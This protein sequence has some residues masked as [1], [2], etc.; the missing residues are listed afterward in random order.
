MDNNILIDDI[1]T[2]A[3]VAGYLKL[4]EKTVLRMVHRGEIPCVKIAS[5]WRFSRNVIDDWLLSRMQVLPKNDLA[6]IIE[7]DS[8]VLPLSRLM[9]PGF[10]QP[11]IRPGSKEDVLRQLIQLLVSAKIVTDEEQ[12]LGK[13]LFRE[14]MA[15]TAIGNGAA[16]PHVRNPEELKHGSPLIISG[17]CREGT[18]FD[19][20]DGKQTHLFFLVY[21]N[22]VVVHVRAIARISRMLV[23]KQIK[24]ELITADTSSDFIH[25]IMKYENLL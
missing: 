12:L 15:S 25:I 21:T 22:S 4:A 6:R 14:A 24:E 11:K 16:M 1:M 19:S 5:Q 20:P 3:E 18:D 13:L 2:L 8:T 7:Q 10:V 9:D 17:I 23:L